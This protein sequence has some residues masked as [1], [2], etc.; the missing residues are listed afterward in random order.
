MKKLC[1]STWALVQDPQCQKQHLQLRLVHVLA[2]AQGQIF[3]QVVTFP[4]TYCFGS[5]WGLTLEPNEFC[6]FTV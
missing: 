3:C 5:P 6:Q 4:R 2:L 1:A